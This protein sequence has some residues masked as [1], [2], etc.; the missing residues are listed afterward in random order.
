M[1]LPITEQL[2]NGHV[3]DFSTIE[4]LCGPRLVSRFS[5]INYEHGVEQGLLRGNSPHVLGSTR[6][7]YDANG[8]FTIYLEEYDILTTALMAVPT[9]LIG[10]YMDKRFPIV[11]TYA[12]PST[13][14]LLVDTL[15]GCRIIRERRGY[16]AGAD[17]LMVD[18][19]IHI[20][21]VTCNN[22]PALLD[23]SGRP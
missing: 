2:I 9:P 18:V 21:K 14:R 1:N 11:V 5:A 20:F 15:T 8:S 19:D 17:A 3:F 10:G 12:E 13:G 7:T 6:G 23:N 22:K 4:A 16:S